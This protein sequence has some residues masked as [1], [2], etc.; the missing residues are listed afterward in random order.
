MAA[1]WMTRVRSRT[2]CRDS[3]V[4]RDGCEKVAT[5][6]VRATVFGSRSQ[7]QRWFECGVHFSPALVRKTELH[8]S[9]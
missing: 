7:T 5:R 2:D 8:C 4:A 9:F 6:D 1:G 3:C